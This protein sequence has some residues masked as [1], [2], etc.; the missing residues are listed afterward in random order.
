MKKTKI[1]LIII[2]TTLLLAL[3]AG[4]ASTTG[5]TAPE[6]KATGQTLVAV[7]TGT[8]PVIDGKITEEAW[9]AAKPLTVTLKPEPGVEPNKITL[10]AL[11]DNENVYLSAVYADSTPLKIGEAWGYDGSTW[12]KGAYDDTL[13]FVWNMADS[14]PAFDQKGLGVMT[15]PLKNGLDVFDFRIDNPSAALLHAKLDFW[16]W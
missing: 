7:K 5:A 1:P 9:K 15:T 2:F 8:A 11:Y 12:T 10:R 3:V 4:C 14:L 6:P 13:A 16:G